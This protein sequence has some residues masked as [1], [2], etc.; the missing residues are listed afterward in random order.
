[1]TTASSSRSL[2]ESR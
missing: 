1:L 2:M